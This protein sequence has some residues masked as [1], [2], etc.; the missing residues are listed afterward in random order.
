MIPPVEKQGLTP[1]EPAPGLDFSGRGEPLL[2]TQGVGGS[3]P[4]VSTS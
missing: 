3:N 2:C 1:P 4:L